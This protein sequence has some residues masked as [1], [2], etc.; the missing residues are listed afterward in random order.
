MIMNGMDY[1]E[2]ITLPVELLSRYAFLFLPLISL[3]FLLPYFLMWNPEFNRWFTGITG[4]ATGIH[5]WLLFSEYLAIKSLTGMVYF[6]V[7]IV[8]HELLH[9]LGWVV[10][11]RKSLRSLQFGVMWKY[12]APYA[13]CNEPVKVSAYRVGI[14]LPGIVIGIIP[15]IYGLITGHLGWIIFGIL[16]TWGAI[17]DFIMWW[18]LRKLAP[19][20]LVIDHPKEVGCYVLKSKEDG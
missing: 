11:G 18:I 7:G 14:I 6:L 19:D 13:H 5:R 16:F 12:L 20:D 17:A 10:F 1:R 8:L 4:D 3:G 2:E 15:G 9:G